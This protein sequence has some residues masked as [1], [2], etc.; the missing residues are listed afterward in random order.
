MA[1]IV[2]RTILK[3]GTRRG[4]NHY[5]VFY[6]EVCKMNSWPT[7][8]IA[9]AAALGLCAGVALAQTSATRA[10]SHQQDATGILQQATQVGTHARNSTLKLSFALDFENTDKA[11]AYGQV[12]GWLK[13]RGIKVLDVS[14]DRTLIRT[15]ATTEIYEHALLIMLYDYRL[16]GQTFVGSSDTPR[17][18]PAV[19]PF[20]SRVFQ[21]VPVH[22]LHRPVSRTNLAGRSASLAPRSVGSN[23]V[24]RMVLGSN[25][26]GAWAAIAPY[27]IPIVDSCAG[28][29]PLTGKVYSVTGV[30]NSVITPASYVYDPMTDSWSPIADFP[31]TGTAGGGLEKPACAF[32]SGK[33]YVTSGDTSDFTVNTTLYIYDPGTDSWS[34]GAD[35]PS[36]LGMEFGASGAALNGMFYVI[37]GCPGSDC[38]TFS[39]EVWAY[40]PASDSWSAAADYPAAV[41]WQGCASAG[42]FL[43]CAG[44]STTGGTVLASAYKYDPGSDTW[45]QVADMLYPNWG[46]AASGTVGGMF[47]LS[48]G[49]NGDTGAI[50]N[51]S[52]GYDVATDTWT[53]LPNNIVTDYRMAGACGFYT[54]GGS[55]FAGSTAASVLSGYTP[56]AVT[57]AT[58][59]VEGTVTDATTG[60]PIEGATVAFTPGT[61]SA[62]TD[63]DGLY[64][65]LLLVGDYTA[66]ATAFG[67]EPSD[68]ASVTVTEDTTTTQDFALTPSATALLGGHVTDS[69]HGY[70]LYSHVVVSYNGSTVADE[71]TNLK[72]GYRFSLP[73]GTTYDITATPYLMG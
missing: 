47:L 43:F 41:A 15:Q 44:G 24:P 64:S 62:T 54:I 46:M 9:A 33:L 16:G 29:D 18:P 71:W 23:W 34:T 63:E 53:M 17:P 3:T 7:K 70:G 1:N 12:I 66:T 25:A 50:T 49:V 5:L 11:K 22:Q 14:A 8:L 37:G 40:N 39:S 30:S 55:P 10:S 35:F 20:V 42:G 31:S 2:E 61:K 56:C 13:S 51:E 32:V 27:P 36:T 48:G 69:G 65:I 38:S 68:P 6:M 19:A 52:Q 59:T 4:T 45:T 58:G 57:G 60:D 28:T 21:P 72:G 26:A 67:Y 73:A